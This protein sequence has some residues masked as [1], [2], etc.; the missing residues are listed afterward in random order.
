MEVTDDA[1]P[2]ER[3]VSIAAEEV[4]SILPTSIAPM[5]SNAMAGGDDIESLFAASPIPSSVPPSTVAESTSA[6]A[7]Q[8]ATDPS[9]LESS[10][11]DTFDTASSL[12]ADATSQSS[13]AS[14][15]DGLDNGEKHEIAFVN[16]NIEDIDALLASIDSDVEVVLL[17]DSRDGLEQITETLAGRSQLQSVHIF[18]HGVDGAFQVG[19]TWIDD[20]TLAWQS[21]LIAS[22]Q[23]SF[24]EDAD[25]LLYGCNVASTADGQAFVEALADLTGADVAAS[26]DA[27]GHASL[28]GNWA[29]EYRTGSIETEFPMDYDAMSDWIDLLAITTNGSASSAQNTGVTSL[30][31]SH[32]VASGSD[33]VMYVTLAID[34]LGASV[35]SV[36]Y[37]GVALTQVGRTTGNHAVEIWRLV[38]PTVGTGTIA[39]SLGATTDIKGGAVVYNG[40]DTSDPNGSYFSA[41]GTS[42]TA[43]V[44]VTSQTNDVVLDITNWDNNPSGYT[45]GAGQSSVWSLTNTA[46]RGI[47]TTEAGAASVTM[48]STVSASNQWEMGA[49]SIRALPNVIV[50]AS[51]DS[52]SISEDTATSID[53]RTNDT[54]G[55][56]NSKT[57]IDYTTPSSGSLSYT[58]D[59]TL[60]YTPTSNYNGTTS[61]QYLTI[62]SG[63]NAT[64][65]WGLNGNGTDTIGGNTATATNGPTT[66]AGHFGNAYAFDE[67]DD[68]LV[69]NDITYN[70]SFTISFNFKIDDNTGTL[71]QYLYSHGTVSTANSVNIYLAE[72]GHSSYANQLFT[73]IQDSNDAAYA[74][75]LNFD[76]SAIVNDGQW[77][78]YTLTVQSG[79]GSK[80]Y[81]DGVLK[82]SN[83]RGGDSIDPTTNLYFGARSDLDASRFLGGSMDSVL[84][85]N[86]G[87]TS[88]EVTSLYS[89]VNRATASVTVTAVNDAPTMTTGYS[90]SLSSTTEDSNSTGTLASAILSSSSWADVDSSPS[91]GLAI[92][93]TTGNGTWQYSTDGT[94]W[95]NFGS[96]SSTNAL[97]I[98]STTQ[99]RYAPDAANAETAT[100][101]YRAWD[102]T[103]GTAST[104]STANYASTSSNGG[105]TAFST[106]LGTASISVS[107]VNDAP[108]NTLPDPAGPFR[109]ITHSHCRGYR[110]QTSTQPRPPCR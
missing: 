35:S 4:N 23:D 82:T 2:E 29:L 27:T 12:L 52:F 94:T 17:D 21:D 14:T 31:W 105:T 101:S 64:H 8:L 83:A 68:Y 10:L 71:F 7:E 70:N 79:V 59:G 76:A 99:V 102:Q 87:L 80:V 45:I 108:T 109:K 40:V 88:S 19:G 44:T 36:T 63:V 3:V 92:T 107:A 41:T 33:R 51:N 15:Q 91:S 75:E 54:D 18:G 85:A 22:W 74:Q 9:S 61:F 25:L 96:V 67:T 20:L 49:I 6:S 24:A 43:S 65:F 86:R 11:N 30:S 81:L 5:D 16:S 46:H 84:V 93:G 73:N 90:Y 97:L 78:T 66:V 55:D 38:S 1:T 28:G 89:Q 47:A 13:D 62:D 103:S 57:I 34:G 32:T 77:H 98:T 69:A 53:P 50:T 26:I 37:G 42:T 48:S 72:S 110:S 39:V 95:K 58:G 104:N 60:T 106:S 100:F 56:G